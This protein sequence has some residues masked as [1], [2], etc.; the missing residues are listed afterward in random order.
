MEASKKTDSMSESTV[1]SEQLQSNEG[2]V[3]M[4]EQQDKSKLEDPIV[5]PKLHI[6]EPDPL[7]N[8]I[9]NQVPS[10]LKKIV[11]SVVAR[12]MMDLYSKT[13][14]Y[15]DFGLSQIVLIA[16]AEF[17]RK[18][19]E[20]IRVSSQS[21]RRMEED[22]PHIRQDLRLVK[23]RA[24]ISD[25]TVQFVENMG[26]RKKS[27]S[28]GDLQDL[29]RIFKQELEV[30]VNNTVQSNVEK[31]DGHLIPDMKK[32]AL[33]IKTDNTSQIMS[34]SEKNLKENPRQVD[35][36]TS[37]G[38]SRVA[39]RLSL[40]DL[41]ERD[42]S[43]ETP[44]NLMGSLTRTILDALKPSTRATKRHGNS[45]KV[46]KDKKSS[47][48]SDCEQKREDHR[49]N[50]ID[51]DED[52]EK[53]TSRI[54]KHYQCLNSR[55]SD[56]PSSLESFYQDLIR[57]SPEYIEQF[58]TKGLS[59]LLSTKGDFDPS[60]EKI[61][62]LITAGKPELDFVS[63]WYRV[64]KLG[65]RLDLI[66][67]SVR[68]MHPVYNKVVLVIAMA[69][70]FKLE[71]IA[72]SFAFEMMNEFSQ[73]LLAQEL[74]ND[75]ANIKTKL[76]EV[77]LRAAS[78]M[79]PRLF[80]G[81]N[82]DPENQESSDISTEREFLQSPFH[83]YVGY[84][85]HY[86]LLLAR[87]IGLA[88]LES[89][90]I[91]PTTFIQEVRQLVNLRQQL[92]KI[93]PLTELV[94]LLFF[95]VAVLIHNW[96]PLAI[97]KDD[98]ANTYIVWVLFSDEIELTR[99]I[100]PLI[101]LAT[102]KWNFDQGHQ[103]AADDFIRDLKRKLKRTSKVL[104]LNY[105]EIKNSFKTLFDKCQMIVKDSLGISDIK[106]VVGKLTDPVTTRPN[107]DWTDECNET[108]L[109]LK[110]KIGAIRGDMVIKLK[111]LCYAVFK[112]DDFAMALISASNSTSDQL[113]S[114]LV[115]MHQLLHM[116]LQFAPV[117]TR[118]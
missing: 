82:R 17:E 8:N 34:A 118:K 105:D 96:L 59:A 88:V 61:S 40:L 110:S 85:V 58:A 71:E 12:E 91:L 53:F 3:K 16:S 92:D 94:I 72:Y 21:E 75:Y 15:L 27:L 42:R 29:T 30:Q 49:Q 2:N 115:A 38:L 98:L 83:G 109:L 19:E 24:F 4:A 55:N 62:S 26:L 99:D 86:E 28:R 44:T 80:E 54:F 81:R 97:D 69:L 46:K 48:L 114:T 100:D 63:P 5:T 7:T 56:N 22:A 37:Q 101:K 35:A 84:I 45:P 52:D 47:I 78:A 113:A 95:R 51:S 112:L 6:G 9:N 90:D 68:E 57:K 60:Y 89:S 23:I 20:T 18:L 116:V 36:T 76:I 108:T 107:L 87:A 70:D 33:L 102:T 73:D 65:Y 11:S 25:I 74:N 67:Q 39:P 106:E 66:Q 93:N 117:I 32:P 13:G 10:E 31:G 14:I 43:K 1:R 41:D 103:D 77:S 79:D 104:K 50:E 111:L 64:K